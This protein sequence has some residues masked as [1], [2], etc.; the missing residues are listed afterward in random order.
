MDSKKI[1]YFKSLFLENKTIK[2]TIFKNTFWLAASEG[3]SKLL[4]LFLLIYV[5]KTLGATEYG[6]FSFALAFIGLFVIFSNL[7]LPRIIV[8]EFSQGKEKEEDFSSILSLKIILSLANLIL[9]SIGSFFITPDHL[10]RKIIWILA[11]YTLL[12][13]F[14]GFINFFFQARQRM[15]YESMAKILRAITVTAFGFFVVFKL[16]SVENLSYS[17]LLASLITLIIV[18]IF[19]HFKIYRINLAFDKSIWQKYLIMSWPLAL[20]GIFTTIYGQIDSV[21]MGYLKQITETGWYN[22]AYRLVGGVLIPLGLVSTS[23]YPALSRAF[24]ESKERFQK[25]FNYQMELMICSA[26]PVGVGGII[27]AP[28]IIDFIYDPTYT[29]SI[30]AFKILIIMAMISFFQNPFIHV[31]LVS[32]Q[33]ARFIWVSI[34]GAC[35][36]VI[37]NLFLIPRYSLYGAAL[38][39][40]ITS[41]VILLIYMKFTHRFTLIKLLNLKLIWTSLLSIFST[42]IM[43][44][45]ISNYNIYNLHVIFT[46]IFGAAAY[47]I[48]FF[49]LRFIIKNIRIAEAPF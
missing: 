34:V 11:A 40:V 12:D 20:A 41:F 28:K 46:I 36:N 25:I 14:A 16:P 23:F 6:K 35:L 44:L 47:F 15:E 48:T 31:L 26:L 38:S 5:A 18:L 39:T 22:A 7:G 30:L 21:I 19:F 3:I 10:I 2:Q 43:Y 33:Q 29:S 1:G 42:L 4:K 17:Y 8:R 27:L 24:K 45:I 37:L 49:I 9:I 32:N 13:S